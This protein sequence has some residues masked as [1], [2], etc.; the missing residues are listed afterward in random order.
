MQSVGR[1]QASLKPAPKKVLKNPEH[2]RIGS[3]FSLLDRLWRTLG[4]SRDFLCQ[5]LVPQIPSKTAGD[6]T[7]NFGCS[8]AELALNC[9]SVNH[10]VYPQPTATSPPAPGSFFFKKNA[11]TNM[12]EQSAPRTQKMSMYDSAPPCRCTDS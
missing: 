6:Q 2:K 12:M 11:R 1:R 4:Q 7:G 5:P 9:Y 8:T 3:P 10:C